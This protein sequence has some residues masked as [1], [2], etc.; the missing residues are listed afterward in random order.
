MSADQLLDLDALLDESMDEVADLPDFITPPAGTYTLGIEDV[1]LEPYESKDKKTKGH[2][3][4]VTYKVIAT[5]ETT[6]P[7]VPDGSLFSERFTYNEQG[8]EFF[9]RA[10][11]KILKDDLQG[12]TFRQ[13]F[14]AMK[15]EVVF[16]AVLSISKSA[17][18]AEGQSYENVR[19]RVI[20]PDAVKK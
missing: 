16:D 8:K 14:D 6:E 1:K 2:R 13:I 20:D 17:P 15:A 10:A 7:P 3:I 5:Q 4:N 19:I 18:N 9:K 12:A 11:K